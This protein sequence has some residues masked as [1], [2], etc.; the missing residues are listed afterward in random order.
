MLRKLQFI[1]ATW[2]VLALSMAACAQGVKVT[3][4]TTQPTPT[5]APVPA[6]SMKVQP[7][8][9]KMTSI[10]DFTMQSIDGKE[11]KLSDYR[12]KTVMIVNVA[13][14]CGYTPQYDGLEQ[15]YEKYKDKGFV[16]LG[17]PANNFGAQEPGSNQDIK[18]FCRLNYGVTFP[19]FAKLSVKGADQHPLYAYLTS[20]DTN[21]EFGGDVTWNFNKFL[22][23]KDCIVVARFPSSD[24]P[25]GDKITKAIE[26][27]L[28]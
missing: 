11:V 6:P 24:E 4:K 7:K 20:K 25:T 27:N 19:M 14:R 1:G 9:K 5:P 26:Q 23:G 21:P 10:Y 3:K 22:I 16:I 15:T 13:S 17:F 28:K 12:G 2:L 18:E 8:D